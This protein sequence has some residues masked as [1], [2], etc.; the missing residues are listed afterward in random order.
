[1]ALHAYPPQPPSDRQWRRLVFDGFALSVATISIRAVL[2][3]RGALGLAANA[4]LEQTNLANP[5]GL[6]LT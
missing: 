2:C 1:M 5:K 4:S 3:G 6:E